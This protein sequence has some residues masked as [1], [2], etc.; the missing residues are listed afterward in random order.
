MRN[1]NGFVANTL[2][3]NILSDVQ[4]VNIRFN[5]LTRAK[6]RTFDDVGRN[7]QNVIKRHEN[8][9]NGIFA[10]EIRLA[11]SETERRFGTRPPTNRSKKKKS[12]EI[13]TKKPAPEKL[14]VLTYAKQHAFSGN[15]G[16][17]Y[18][19]PNILRAR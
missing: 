5:I 18:T 6:T 7:G 3:H 9:I 1:R 13:F 14:F 12:I 11:D 16:E 4:P 2:V 17:I 10:F 19:Q 8:E 15:F